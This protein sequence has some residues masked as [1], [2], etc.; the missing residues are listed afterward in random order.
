MELTTLIYLAD[1]VGGLTGFLAILGLFTAIGG[2]IACVGTA[3]EKQIKASKIAA[4]AATIGLL[5][6]LSAVLIPSKQAIYMIF[7][8]EVAQKVAATPEA[9]EIA[10]KLLK[11][12]NSK[13]DEALQKK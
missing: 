12:A 9:Q 2:G 6:V 7:G 10:G 4:A 5:L 11:L 1:I 3:C 13:L 8:A